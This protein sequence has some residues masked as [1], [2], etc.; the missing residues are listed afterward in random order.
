MDT[1]IVHNDDRVWARE[2]IHVVEKTINKTVKLFRSVRVVF[3]NEVK[4]PIERKGGK[5]RVSV[6]PIRPSA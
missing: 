2:L 3:N 4:D 5:N 6:N 1:C